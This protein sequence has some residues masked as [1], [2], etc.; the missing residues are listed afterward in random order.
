MSEVVPVPG[1]RLVETHREALP[2]AQPASLIPSK[3]AA[4][5]VAF[6]D[7]TFTPDVAVVEGDRI[8]RQW[9]MRESHQGTFLGVPAT[10]RTVVM[11]GIDVL[12]VGGDRVVEIWH[13]ENVPGLM[14]QFGAVRQPGA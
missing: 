9:T 5:G 7:R 14:Q 12:L 6:P 13:N 2:D 3:A 1:A 4:P 10:A 8:V 11:T